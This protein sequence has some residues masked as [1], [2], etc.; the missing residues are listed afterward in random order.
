[1]HVDLLAELRSQP[2]RDRAAREADEAV[3]GRGHATVDGSGL[4]D[5]LRHEGVV[6]AEEQA[7]DD[8]AYRENSLA[9]RPK[10]HDDEKPGQQ[11]QVD[12]QGRD[13][14]VAHLQT[15]GHDDRGEGQGDAPAEEDEADLV[16]THVERERGEREEGEEA[17]VVEKR[18][19]GHPQ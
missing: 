1:V 19:D 9:V 7:G 17:E 3:C 18:G 16:S 4:R 6:D 14:A 11:R 12:Q 8:D 5:R 15:R 10:G 13:R 2:R